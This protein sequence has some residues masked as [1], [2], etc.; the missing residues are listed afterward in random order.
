MVFRL[1][2]PFIDID[3]VTQCLERIKRDTHRQK[4]IICRDVIK[5]IDLVQQKI[6]AIPK[7]IEV[8]EEE[9]QSQIGSQ[10]SQQNQQPYHAY[11]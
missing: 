3:C 6:N 8:F 1:L 9:E 10:A 4:K 5:N 2:F 11:I 7:K